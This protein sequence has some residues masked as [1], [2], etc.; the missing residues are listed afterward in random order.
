MSPSQASIVLETP[1]TRVSYDLT[2]PNDDKVHLGAMAGL[3]S[4]VLLGN[5]PTSFTYAKSKFHDTS[6][7]GDR[8][9]KIFAMAGA[10]IN[11][12]APDN[13]QYLEQSDKTWER[14]LREVKQTTK[15]SSFADINNLPDLSFKME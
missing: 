7:K 2:E 8:R 6:T 11:F 5:H 10:A 12:Y 1:M 4:G 14:L 15:F 13:E 9:N 3:T